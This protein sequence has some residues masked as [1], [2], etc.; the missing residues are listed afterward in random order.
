MSDEYTVPINRINSHEFIT[1]DNK[2]I[3]SQLTAV[4]STRDVEFQRKAGKTKGKA[5][6]E[7]WKWAKLYLYQEYLERAR[8]TQASKRARDKA[9]LTP[10]QL[11]CH[12]TKEREWAK[13]YREEKKAD[14]SQPSSS[15]R[16]CVSTTLYRRMQT[17]GT[18]IQ[19]V[20]KFITSTP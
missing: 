3:S 10:Y 13:A 2:V 7:L 5:Q 9:K 1:S 8:K 17:L 15:A 4:F 14:T 16:H 20:L 6:S 18:A 12:E 11:E 19:R